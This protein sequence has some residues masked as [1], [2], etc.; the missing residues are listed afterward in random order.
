MDMS[1]RLNNN[2][3]SIC[4]I[5]AGTGSS[6]YCQNCIRDVALVHNLKQ[7]GHDVTVVP[8]YLPLV[9]DYHESIKRSP[10]FFGA[11][12][13]Y[14]REQVPGMKHMPGLLERALDSPVMLSIA[15]RYA[16]STDPQGHEALTVSMLQGKGGTLHEQVGKLV[17]W[18][19]EQPGFDIIHIS[20]ALLSGLAEA[21]RTEVEIPIICSLQDEDSWLTGMRE[22]WAGEAWSLIEH[23]AG[24]IDRFIAVSDWYADF[25]KKRL[26]GVSSRIVTL[27]PGVDM[28]EYPGNTGTGGR[29]IG[30]LARICPQYGFDILVDAFIEMK[31]RGGSDDIKLKVM[32]GL[33]PAD[34]KFISTMIKKLKRAEVYQD[35]HFYND[36]DRQQRLELFAGISVLAL[37]TRIPEAFGNQ[38]LEAMAAGVPVITPEIGGYPELVNKAGGGVLIRDMNSNTLLKSL[39]NLL[40]DTTERERLAQTGRESI[41]QTMTITNMI[42]RL[43]SRYND[44]INP[45]ESSGGNNEN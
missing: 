19:K 16:G 29:N 26:P 25:F 39:E 28:I 43:V 31:K 5:V 37:P 15:A 21:I 4:Y 22:P 9:D 20:N 45:T 12:S 17:K 36:F 7:Q 27:Y 32:G 38:L 30:Y 2:K 18:I 42:T 24:Y 41:S 44:C 3:L 6:F 23:Q 10:L 33:T 1:M 8:L 11:V 34:K 40:N 14:F 13:T 35:V